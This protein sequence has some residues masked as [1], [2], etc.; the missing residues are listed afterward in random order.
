[1]K[2]G[3]KEPQDPGS[4]MMI[5]YMGFLFASYIW[6]NTSDL[7]SEKLAIRKQQEQ[8]KQQ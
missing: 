3:E 4:D 5:S 8:T 7:E 1:M 6:Q 2:G